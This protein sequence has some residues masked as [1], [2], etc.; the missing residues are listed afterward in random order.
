M[1]TLDEPK[2][3]NDLKSCKACGSVGRPLLQVVSA[4]TAQNK[5]LDFN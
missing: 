3:E 4:F 1:S 5:Y 2:F